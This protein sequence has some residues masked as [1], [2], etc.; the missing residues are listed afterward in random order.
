[1]EKPGSKDHK[2]N[3]G[4]ID[5]SGRQYA[6]ITDPAGDKVG[7]FVDF[8]WLDQV[9]MEARGGRRREDTDKWKTMEKNVRDK[10][11]EMQKGELLVTGSGT[12]VTAPPPLEVSMR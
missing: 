8:V 6:K 9:G 12:V 3:M 10:R 11:K 4:L 1:M 5:H 2:K 7:V